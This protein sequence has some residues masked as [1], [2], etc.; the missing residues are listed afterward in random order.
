L[1]AHERAVRV[2]RGVAAPVFGQQIA[3]I[4]PQIFIPIHHDPC[5][6]DVK[7]ELDGESRSCPMR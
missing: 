3:A 1:A 6:F 4:E 2:D 7:V 5:A